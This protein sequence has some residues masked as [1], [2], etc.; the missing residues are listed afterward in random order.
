MTIIGTQYYKSRDADGAVNHLMKESVDR[1]QREQ[2]MVDDI[3]IMVAFLN[4][5]T[6][7]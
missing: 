5:G 6:R 2:G 1:W 4:A 7:S 3:T